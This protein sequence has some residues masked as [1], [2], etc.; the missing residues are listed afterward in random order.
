MKSKS[1][2]V[3]LTN[4][5]SVL[6]ALKSSEAEVARLKKALQNVGKIASEAQAHSRLDRL[7]EGVR[8]QRTTDELDELAD[9]QRRL[10]ELAE[11]QE[12][13]RPSSKEA[14]EQYL[15]NLANGK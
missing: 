6:K 9:E 7:L 4:L 5:G 2:K 13:S 14:E 3:C 10:V 8:F 15:D 1:T 12:R 11:E